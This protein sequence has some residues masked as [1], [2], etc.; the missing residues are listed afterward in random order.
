MRKW[1]PKILRK[2]AASKYKKI[3]GSDVVRRREI[4]TSFAKK[5]N[6]VYFHTVG[7][8]TD[9]API[10]RGSTATPSHVDSNF[11]I[12]THAGYDMTVIERTADVDFVG[13]ES[14]THRW[15]V[16][17]IDLK[18]TRSAPYIF[19][20]TKQLT[21][22]FFAKVLVSHRNVRY[23]Q[24]ES[25]HSH[26]ATFHGTYALVASPASLPELHRLF[27]D[28]TLHTIAEHKYPFSIEIEGD[29]MILF[30]EAEK[31]NEQLIDKLLH[32]GLWLAKRI[33][34]SID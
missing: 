23:M 15:Y 32:Y 27:N 30:T 10:I 22:A 3:G 16:L 6:L 34:E 8:D 20:G 1:H 28:E 9:N 4:A 7:A 11:C 5:H 14:T 19:L 12:G 25:P 13:F 24:L 26:S 18:H 21:K 31:P 29:S 17:E 33:D 2:K